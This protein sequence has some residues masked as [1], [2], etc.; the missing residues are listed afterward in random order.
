MK[1]KAPF[2]EVKGG[3]A[4]FGVVGDPIKHSKSPLIHN[5]W[6]K[7]S[8]K[9]AHYQAF[10]LKSRN[11]EAIEALK[12]AY[13]LGLSGL[14]ITLP[15]KEAAFKA[16]TSLT[17]PAQTIGAVNTLI[18]TPQGWQGHNSDAYGF[19][20]ALAQKMDLKKLEAQAVLMIG[21]GGAMRAIAFVLKGL[22]AKLYIA[23]RTPLRAE[24]LAN[25]M[26]LEAKTLSLDEVE[27]IAPDC[28]L[29][30]NGISAGH[31]GALPFELPSSAMG[32]L[33]FDLSYGAAAAPFITKAASSRWQTADGL[34][35]LLYQA[36]ESY[37]HWFGEWPSMDLAFN[38]LNMSDS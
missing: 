32:G 8:G 16:A 26:C 25:D 33:A 19:Q 37:Y 10:H 21:A 35:M 23:N 36:A 31:D 17:G 15:H 6:L 12:A 18:R 1:G 24:K 20:K 13:I 4:I 5:T 38:A 14:N 11:S 7:A 3:T 28:R 30:I 34:S 9:G 27:T 29:V 22:G 2:F